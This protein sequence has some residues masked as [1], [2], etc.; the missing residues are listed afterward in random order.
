MKTLLTVT[1]ALMVL[2][3]GCEETE[4]PET[5]AYKD[6][7]Q[8]VRAENRQLRIQVDTANRMLATTNLVLVI[9]GSCLASTLIALG[10]TIRRN[11][12]R[13]HMPTD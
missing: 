6:S 1:A 12:W 11:K 8:V 9:T 13:T 10:F 3:S 7:L 4:R 2:A 5:T